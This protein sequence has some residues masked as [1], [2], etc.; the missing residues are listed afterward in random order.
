MKLQFLLLSL[1]L[2]KTKNSR[3]QT[4]LLASLGV[5]NGVRTAGGTARGHF[6][7]S[8]ADGK[9]EENKGEHCYDDTS[10]GG[11]GDC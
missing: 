8:G 3:T 6:F 1:F 11:Y 10:D 5:V 2:P 4:L 7:V 9:G